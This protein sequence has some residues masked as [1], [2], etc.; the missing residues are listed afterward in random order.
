ML[1][2]T[3]DTMKQSCSEAMNNAGNSF[4]SFVVLLHPKSR[5]TI[6]LQSSDPLDPPLID[7]NYLNHPDDLKALL[8][9]N[10]TV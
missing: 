8:K 10:K 1:F 3:K 9:G 2:Q 6:Q 4:M 7:P 5:G